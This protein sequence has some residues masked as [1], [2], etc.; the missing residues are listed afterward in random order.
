DRSTQ[1][2]GKYA[3]IVTEIGGFKTGQ[4]VDLADVRRGV[5]EDDRYGARYVRG[6][7]RGGFAATHWQ[8][9]FVGVPHARS[10][11]KPEEP[12]EKHCRSHGDNGKAR[13]GQ[14][15]FR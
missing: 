4:I 1:R 6:R 14:S 8:C 12:I 13:P 2:L 9:Q 7:D 10:S 5:F 11:E 15:L 3:R